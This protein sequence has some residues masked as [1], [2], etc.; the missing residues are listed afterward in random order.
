MPSSSMPSLLQLFAGQPAAL[1]TPLRS[2][3]SIAA[4]TS[5]GPTATLENHSA[6]RKP[7]RFDSRRVRAV[8][9]RRRSR[10]RPSP[11]ARRL[12]ARR[13]PAGGPAH[14]LRPRACPTPVPEWGLACCGARYRSRARERLLLQPGRRQTSLVLYASM[15]YNQT[16][17]Q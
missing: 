14:V 8:R 9:G 2:V 7:S 13:L 17:S 1:L 5:S 4:S 12:A 15:T 10:T 16:C 11:G 6:R 3:R